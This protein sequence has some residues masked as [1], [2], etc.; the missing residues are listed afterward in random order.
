MVCQHIVDVGFDCARRIALIRD[1]TLNLPKE[2]RT[3]LNH[4]KSFTRTQICFIKDKFFPVIFN[5]VI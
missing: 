2:V 3:D 5:C 4:H 1:Y